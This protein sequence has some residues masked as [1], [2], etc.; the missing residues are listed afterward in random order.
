MN[1]IVSTML[2]HLTSSSRFEGSL[3]VDINEI[4]MNLVPFP[5]MH[6]LVPAVSPLY[7]LADVAMQPRRY[8]KQKHLSCRSF[9]VS[10]FF[11]SAFMTMHSFVLTSNV[12]CRMDQIFTDAFSK[13]FQLVKADPRHHTCVQTGV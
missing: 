12:V 4:T 13:E 2:L 9:I 11:S 10:A 6:Y 8:C 1:N 5:R 7:D 3:N